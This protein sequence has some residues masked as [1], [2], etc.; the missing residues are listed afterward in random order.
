MRRGI[1]AAT[2]FA[3]SAARAEEPQFWREGWEL[4]LSLGAAGDSGET[5]S[6]APPGGDAYVAEN[7]GTGFAFGTRFAY[8]PIPWVGPYFDIGLGIPS[9]GRLFAPGFGVAAYPVHIWRIDPYVDL[10]SSYTQWN[11]KTLTINGADA[12]ASVTL[13]GAA[14]HLGFG[15]PVFVLPWLAVG[16][17]FRYE[18]AFWQSFCT[19]PGDCEE[20]SDIERYLPGFKDTLPKMWRFGVE[21]VFHPTRP[22]P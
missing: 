7:P 2:L 8:R 5:P 16:P 9:G 6:A 13:H 21:A 1:F 14:F 11:T 22:R 10:G 15:A 20:V 17:A 12:N 4:S 19:D 18:I 3:F